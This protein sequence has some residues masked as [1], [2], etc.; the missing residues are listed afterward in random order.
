M[1]MTACIPVLALLIA[2]GCHRQT[3]S[4]AVEHNYDTR[5]DAIDRTAAAQPTAIAKDIYRDQ[6]DALRQE[7]KERAQGL[8]KAGVGDAPA[9]E[10]H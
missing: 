8:D 4:D 9:N 5:A 6:A 2:A 1:R 3:V 7:G 10:S